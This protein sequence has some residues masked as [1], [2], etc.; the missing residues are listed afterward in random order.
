MGTPTGP[1]LTAHTLA[2]ALHAN[3]PISMQARHAE[4]QARQAEQ[5]AQASE[6]AQKMA[7]YDKG[8]FLVKGRSPTSP[9]LASAAHPHSPSMPQVISLPLHLRIAQLLPAVFIPSYCAV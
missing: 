8:G 1:F 6:A 3:P 7:Q 4:Q 5:V 2:G 9:L